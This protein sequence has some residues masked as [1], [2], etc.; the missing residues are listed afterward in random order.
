[1]KSTETF[2]TR[3]GFPSSSSNFS[4]FGSLKSTETYDDIPLNLRENAISAIS[5]R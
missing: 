2:E 3:S 1:L 5:A 4:N